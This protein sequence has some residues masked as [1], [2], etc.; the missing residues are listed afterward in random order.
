MRI[1]QNSRLWPTLLL[2]LTLA[3]AGVLAGCNAATGKQPTQSALSRALRI[4]FAWPPLN[5]TGRAVQ[6]PSTAL[7]ATLTIRDARVDSGDFIFTVSRNQDTGAHTENYTSPPGVKSGTFPISIGFYSAPNGINGTGSL[8]GV[9]ASTIT[10]AEDG[11]TTGP[12]VD[13]SAASTITGIEISTL[14]S[15]GVGLQDRLSAVGK[16]DGADIPLGAGVLWQVVSGA[17]KLQIDTE[18][19]ITG[20]TEGQATVRASVAV[21][22]NAVASAERTISVASTPTRPRFTVLWNARSRAL[23][24]PSSA[25][26]V[27][28]ALANSA[29]DTLSSQTVDRQADPASYTQTV[30]L[31]DGITIPAGRQHLT[32]TFFAQPGGQGDVVGTISTDVA[33]A[34][35]GSGVEQLNLTYSRIVATV[36]ITT[37]QTLNIGETRQ[38]TFAARDAAGNLLAVTP[39]SAFWQ[40]TSGQNS[41]SVTTDGIATGLSAGTAGVG[42]TVDGVQSTP[43][44]ITITSGKGGVGVGIE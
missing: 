9:I 6:A 43:T 39:G 24:A 20:L 23:T 2:A 37:N 13:A 18:G 31:P 7:S 14:N 22:I 19:R 32:A 34:V 42:V 26:S 17:D 44:V 25:L 33:V 21:G 11:S 8:V 29:G 38:L 16:T 40:V 1:C 28:L 5:S 10:I 35:D 36:D 15:V 4:A 3:A 30:D 12:A 41:L 27:T